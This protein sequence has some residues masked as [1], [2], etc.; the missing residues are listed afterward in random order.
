MGISR[1]C[2]ENDRLRRKRDNLEKAVVK[3]GCGDLRDYQ[4]FR[5][6]RGG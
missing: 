6:R 3:K 4:E 5:A 1:L 2:R